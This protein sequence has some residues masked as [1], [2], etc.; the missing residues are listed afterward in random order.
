MGQGVPRRWGPQALPE[1]GDAA[2]GGGAAIAF[3]TDGSTLNQMNF[4][5]YSALVSADGSA[6]VSVSNRGAGTRGL[7][8]S[9]ANRGKGGDHICAFS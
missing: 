2:Q 7:R 5:N 4:V 8:S 9:Q 1:F 6:L 3:L